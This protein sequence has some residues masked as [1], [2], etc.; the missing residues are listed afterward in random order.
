MENKSKAATDSTK[1]LPKINIPA[2]WLL[3]GAFIVWEVF[4]Y[5]QKPM[6]VKDSIVV[7]DTAAIFDERLAEGDSPADARLYFET[8]VN[9]YKQNDY[10][11]IP[12][13]SLLGA[14]QELSPKIPSKASLMNT[15]RDMGLDV[16]LERHQKI[17]DEIEKAAQQVIDALHLK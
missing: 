17:Q 1:K 13:S 6:S 9:V 14:P 11:V 4:T 3:A 12:S 16:S 5:S 15:A 10:I 2:I 8:L 7:L